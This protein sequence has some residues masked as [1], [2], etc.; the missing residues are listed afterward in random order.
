MRD[1]IFETMINV[2]FKS[3][4]ILKEHFESHNY[5]I[6]QKTTPFDLVTNADE[7]SQECII[8][9]LSSCYPDIAI[10]S[11]EG[12]KIK[13][14]D[15]VFYVDPLD[16]TLNFVH[17][18]P[19]FAVSIG[20]WEH[21]KAIFGVVFDPIRKNLFYAEKGIGAFLNGEKIKVSSTRSLKNSLLVT[22]WPYNKDKISGIID[23]VKYILKFTEFL[24][25]GSAALELC[26]VASGI[27][28][29]YWEYS[30]CPWDL[31]A[32]ILI[33][34]EAGA[35]ISTPSGKDFDL[36]KG[37]VLAIVPN[38]KREFTELIREKKS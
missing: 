32:G 34:E 18:F 26:Y 16:G 21:G 25:L 23:E 13:K 29:G 15:K 7:E 35:T 6:T 2:C 1:S 31:A 8:S 33:A 4:D 28:D 11:E 10:I 30:L 9:T 20:Y 17:K 14:Y 38:L 37:D 19:F 22:G 5:T 24:S 36:F 27:F 12:A 3:G